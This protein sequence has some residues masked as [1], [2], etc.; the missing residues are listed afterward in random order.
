VIALRRRLGPV[1]NLELPTRVSVQDRQ[2]I[3]YLWK[4]A[5]NTLRISKEI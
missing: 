1:V 2:T 4:A 5:A 3:G